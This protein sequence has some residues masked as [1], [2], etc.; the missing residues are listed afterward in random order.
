VNIVV[1]GFEPFGGSEVNASWEAVRGLADVRIVLLPVAFDSAARR[2]REIVSE[3]PDAVICVGEAG[4]R[5]VVSIER[6]AIN[7]ID[8][9][10]PDNEGYRPVDEPVCPDRPAAWFSTLPVRRIL[11]RMQ[12]GGIPAEL[13]CTAGTYVCNTVFYSLM[14]EIDRSG[15]KIPGGFIHVPAKGM[16]IGQIRD[17]LKI[18]VNCL[19]E[20]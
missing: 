1:T 8:A 11:E 12:G 16:D 19:K 6:V 15:I 20:D 9:R 5:G 2:I 13:S 4:G 10:I 14:D 17:A 7:L 18:A 3:K